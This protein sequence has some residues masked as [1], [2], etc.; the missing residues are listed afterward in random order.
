MKK[1]SSPVAHET[2]IST[3]GRP[4]PRWSCT[5]TRICPG[6]PAP[7]HIRSLFTRR[8]AGRGVGVG[9][10]MAIGVRR[11]IGVAVSVGVVDGMGEAWATVALAVTVGWM[12]TA[13]PL[14]ASA[15]AA[16]APTAR[17]SRPS[18]A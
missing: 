11:G 10:G 4:T 9:V 14:S 2:R 15:R 7:E 12:T 8:T 5:Y 13:L 17:G 6:R 18:A 16:S 3:L 1:R